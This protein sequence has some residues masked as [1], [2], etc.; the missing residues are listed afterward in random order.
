MRGILRSPA[1]LEQRGQS[2]GWMNRGNQNLVQCS[3]FGFMP[4]QSELAHNLAKTKSITQTQ[5]W[6][7]VLCACVLH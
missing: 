4:K 6:G 5:V 2:C 3:A 7:P 1:C